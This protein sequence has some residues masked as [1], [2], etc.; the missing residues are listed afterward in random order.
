MVVGD[1]Y[2]NWVFLL[3]FVVGIGVDGDD[4]VVVGYL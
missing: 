3:G 1:F 4:M 2:L